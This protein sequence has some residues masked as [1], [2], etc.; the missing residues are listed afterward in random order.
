TNMKNQFEIIAK[1]TAVEVDFSKD[2]KKYLY[3]LLS[4]DIKNTLLKVKKLLDKDT[5][6]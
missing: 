2:I 3:C 1:N 5:W 4:E 6:P